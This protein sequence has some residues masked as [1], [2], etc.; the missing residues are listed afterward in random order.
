[1][2]NWHRYDY[3]HQTSSSTS[4]PYYSQTAVREYIQNQAD[5]QKEKID[6]LKSDLKKFVWS[7][8]DVEITQYMR[9]IMGDFES[10]LK[11]ED[12]DVVDEPQMFY[13][14]PKGIVNKWP[15][16]KES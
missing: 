12:A 5:Y 7:P 13:F 3:Y 1:M 6:E 16:K 2:S 15:E 8:E 10:Q 11:Q 9:S 4:S 14:D